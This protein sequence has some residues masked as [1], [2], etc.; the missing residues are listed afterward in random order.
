MHEISFWF[1]LSE[2]FF[3][4]VD[5]C[6]RC[7]N[8]RLISST[9]LVYFYISSLGKIYEGTLLFWQRWWKTLRKMCSSNDDELIDSSWW[10][11]ATDFILFWKG[12]VTVS[13]YVVF[14]SKV[15][16]FKV[17]T[18]F[19]SYFCFI[20]F[21]IFI[22]CVVFINIVTDWSQA[23]RPRHVEFKWRILSPFTWIISPH[24][25]VVSR[26]PCKA[27]GRI[28]WNHWHP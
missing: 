23:W 17:G 22:S 21:W 13:P 16:N 27:N 5:I 10:W 26:I 8:W 7:K 24:A 18:Y 12:L 15:S 11:R 28:S 2:F 20:H 25:F 3:T 19:F 9:T 6:L 1:E 4:W 14:S